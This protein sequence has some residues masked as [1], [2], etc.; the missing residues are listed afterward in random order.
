MSLRDR[1]LLAGISLAA[2]AVL[3]VPACGDDDGAGVRESGEVGSG[4]GSG[5]GS[6]PSSGSDVACVEV[7]D[8][9]A[10]D[11]TVGADLTEYS[12]TLDAE[13]APAGYVAFEADNVG[14]EPHELVVARFDGDPADLPTD[15]DGAVDE[16]ALADAAVIGEIEPFPAGEVCSGAFELEAGS[17]ALFCNIVEEEDGEVESHYAEGMHTGFTVE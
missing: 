1:R 14:A 5:S 7:G 10:A 17:Y 6:G 4:S 13:S 11:T 16:S 3:A 8:P 9:D 15:D 12:I 2:L